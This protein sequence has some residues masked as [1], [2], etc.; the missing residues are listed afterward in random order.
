MLKLVTLA[1]LVALVATS[2]TAQ[3]P[4]PKAAAPAAKAKETEKRRCERSVEETGSRV[5]GKKIC[6]TEAE[7]AAERQQKPKGSERSQENAGNSTGR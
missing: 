2:A 5:G 3:T 6:K 7:W 4:P 1:A